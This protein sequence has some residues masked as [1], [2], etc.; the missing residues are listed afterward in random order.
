MYIYLQKI[1]NNCL[2]LFF[3]AGI[4]YDLQKVGKHRNLKNYNN[5]HEALTMKS[6]PID[7]E[8]FV[9]VK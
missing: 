6:L 8:V 2:N 3:V 9:I 4:H 5:K 1:D 7:L